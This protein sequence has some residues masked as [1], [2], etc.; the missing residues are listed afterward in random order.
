MSPEIDQ[1]ASKVEP[2]VIAWRRDIHQN[3]ELG[4][5]EFRTSTLVAE[6][7]RKLG[8]EVTTKVAHTGVVGILRGRWPDPV[9][10]LRTDMDALP[11]RKAIDLPFA[12]RAK[13][14]YNGKETSVAHACGHDAHTAILMGVAE[15]L[16]SGRERL[17]GTVKFIFQPAEDSKP[18]GEEGG[19][20]LMIREGVL[21]N[22][23][24]EAIFGLHVVPL[25][26]GIIGYRPVGLMAGVDN[27]R[28]VVRG[29]GTHGGM[30][31]F[32]VDPVPVAAQIVLGLQS[33]VSRQIDPTTA[34]AVLTV[35]VIR[36]AAS[37]MWCRAKS[38]SAA[39][40]GPSIRA[41]A[42]IFRSA[43][44]PPQPPLPRPPGRAPR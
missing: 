11:V 43:S 34:P 8:M 23:K 10:A 39:P 26:S 42:A 36:V 41:C 28:I 12:S 37:S 29:R 33:I 27:F 14:Q 24:P 25:P 15:V 31:W 32:G 21:D 38:R 6:H 5:R 9:V 13:A 7:L 19:A 17:P 4:N 18:D 22:P 1:L 44:R 35:G 40:S 30:P 16:V 2:K 3:P 20:D